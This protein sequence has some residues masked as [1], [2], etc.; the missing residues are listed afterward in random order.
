MAGELKTTRPNLLHR[1]SHVNREDR[2]E[3]NNLT[4]TF[5]NW[6]A[7]NAD[8]NPSLSSLSTKDSEQNK[9]IPE[10]GPGP[11]PNG[12]LTAWLQVLGAFFLNFNTW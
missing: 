4:S 1:K 5:D 9:Q 10:P 12:G 2:E 11:P 6:P 7:T 3:L 8:R